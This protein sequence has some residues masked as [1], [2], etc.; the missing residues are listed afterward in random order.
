MK[1]YWS[2]LG[3]QVLVWV[4]IYSIVIHKYDVSHGSIL[5]FPRWIG[6]LG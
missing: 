1:E 4:H 6:K 3:L 2:G 5:N